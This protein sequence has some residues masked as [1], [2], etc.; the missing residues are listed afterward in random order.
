MFHPDRIQNLFTS[1]PDLS[2][3][4]RL[5]SIRVKHALQLPSSSSAPTNTTASSNTTLPQLKLAP[6]DIKKGSKV[7]YG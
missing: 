4:Q 6:L 5:Q 3:S 7:S 1:C 2:I